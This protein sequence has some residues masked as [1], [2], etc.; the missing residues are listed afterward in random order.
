MQHVR[1]YFK[2]YGW[3]NA[4]A[5]VVYFERKKHYFTKVKAVGRYLINK[6][7]ESHLRLNIDISHVVTDKF[8]NV[9]LKGE[10]KLL[11]K[12]NK[13]PKYVICNMD[14]Q[15]IDMFNG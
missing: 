6:Y 11:P 3:F 15:F 13:H 7:I 14:Y 12:H 9:I 5:Y 8:D 10:K 1:D 2:R 4:A